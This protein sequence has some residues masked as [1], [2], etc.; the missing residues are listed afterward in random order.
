[1][2]EDESG[3]VA[4]TNI[5]VNSMV[6]GV[7][8]GVSGKVDEEG[9]FKCISCWSPGYAPQAAIPKSMSSK[10]IVLLSGLGFGKNTN[11]M[12]A[13]LVV[14]YISGLV[15]NESA[16]RGAGDIVRVVI[17]GNLTNGN[18]VQNALSKNDA[19]KRAVLDR[20]AEAMQQA[21]L[22]LAQLTSCVHVDI[23]P[24][25]TDAASNMLPQQPLHHCLFPYSSRFSSFRSVSNPYYAAV[26]GIE[27]LGTSGEN[28]SSM[29]QCTQ[30]LSELECMQQTLEWRHL[31]PT[32]PDSL[33]KH[34]IRCSPLY[35]IL[36]CYPS[37][38]TDPFVLQATPHVYFAGNQPSFQTNLVQLGTN[39][40]VRVISIPDFSA[41][42][43]MV[44]LNTSDLSVKPIQFSI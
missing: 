12:A 22:W 18:N 32:A 31:A 2:L 15:G 34:I 30:N 29:K 1:M 5:S 37:S 35:K 44:L 42:G 17:A 3:R 36:D 9:I 10:Y 13:Q 33:R 7:I 6:T 24:G 27:L 20:E 19:N 14:E 40:N 8:L 26:D 39:Q 28:I 23:M 16:Q 11:P 38:D 43:T 41:T 4:I 25:A 21:D